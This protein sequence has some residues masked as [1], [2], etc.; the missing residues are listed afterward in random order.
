MRKFLA[1]CAAAFRHG[2]AE[3]RAEARAQPA[4]LAECHPFAGLNEEQVKASIAAALRAAHDQGVQ[5]ERARIAEVLN[6]PGAS[7]FP[8]IAIDL[9][10]GT[11]SGAQAAAVLSRAETDAAKRAGLLKPVPLESPPSAPT[12]H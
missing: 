6:A 11:A 12:V 2:Y 3:A 7:L 10:L 4:P 8:T 5:A 1:F 9:A